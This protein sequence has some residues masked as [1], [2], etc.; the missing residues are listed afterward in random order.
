MR[1]LY[2]FYTGCRDGHV[3]FR[4]SFA[5]AGLQA[6]R[7]SHYL[8]TNPQEAMSQG[9]NRKSNKISS[10]AAN[11]PLHWLELHFRIPVAF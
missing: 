7:G 4:Q 5:K 6:S 10:P 3:P 8:M 9:A 1:T 11:L 2:H